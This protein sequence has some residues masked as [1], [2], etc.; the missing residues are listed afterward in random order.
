MRQT[1]DGRRLLLA[2]VLLLPALVFVPANV[3]KF[4]LN[5]SFPY[6][7]LEPILHPSIGLLRV[8]RDVL[9][10][11]GP[12][13]A[14]AL[15][16]ASIMRGSLKRTGDSVQATVALRIAPVPMAIAAVS[17]VLLGSIAAYLVA[18]NLL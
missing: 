1:P 13:A 16:A 2:A 6:D 7:T 4:E 15:S 11:L 9:V 18:E 17:L 12:V 8:L 5:I 10:V 3:L 14:L